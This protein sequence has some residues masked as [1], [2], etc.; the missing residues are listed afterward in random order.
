M[1]MRPSPISWTDRNR[2]RSYRDLK[3]INILVN[4]EGIPTII[5]FGIAKAAADDGGTLF[6]RDTQT[7][8]TPAYMSP[9]QASGDLLAPLVQWSDVYSL[10]VVLYELLLRAPPFDPDRLSRTGLAEVQ[11]ILAEEEPTA[12]S[13]TADDDIGVKANRLS[14]A[15]I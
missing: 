13:G 9:E 4:S 10:G 11:K 14:A 2:D 5:D 12:P 3:T 15:K 6:T 8:G 7:L 1:S